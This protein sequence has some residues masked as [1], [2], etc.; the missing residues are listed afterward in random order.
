[1]ALVSE[2]L[3]K[4][5]RGGRLADE[6]KAIGREYGEELAR[7]AVALSDAIEAFTFFRQSLDETARQLAHQA[8]MSGEEA[9]QT[10][11][12]VSVLA[13]VVLVA[14][15]EAYEALRQVHGV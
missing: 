9:A 7:D 12:Q 14:M 3:E 8:G 13:D 5:V 6:A 2:C 1:V 11:E 15:I 10:W 4:R